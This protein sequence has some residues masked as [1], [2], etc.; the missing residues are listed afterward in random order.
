M[1]NIKVFT[2]KQ[3]AQFEEFTKLHPPVGANGIKM[4]PNYILLTYEDG[5]VRDKKLDISYL[6]GELNTLLENEIQ[7]VRQLKDAIKTLEFIDFYTRKNEWKKF[8]ENLTP[9]KKM[10]TMTQIKIEVIVEILKELGKTLNV[11][12]Q[13]LPDLP[14]EP[15]LAKR[16]K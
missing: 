2:D 1:L 7:E 16:D 11:E 13:K 15:I 10:I 8:H 5:Q 14:E 4:T 9:M 12:L 6:T 3:F